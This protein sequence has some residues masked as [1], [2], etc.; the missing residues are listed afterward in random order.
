MGY[1]KPESVSQEIT[2]QEVVRWT[3]A[4]LD[5]HAGD[6]RNLQIALHLA[7]CAGCQNYV[8]QIASV[9]NLAGLLPKAFEKPRDPSRIQV[10]FSKKTR[11]SS[12]HR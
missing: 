8:D 10:S 12:D 1:E 3:S 7:V 9:R 11:R 4:Y 5:E 2:C 6:E